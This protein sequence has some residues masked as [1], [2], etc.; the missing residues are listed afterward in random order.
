MGEDGKPGEGERVLNFLDAG[1]DQESVA[2]FAF[3]PDGR[4]AVT[5]GHGGRRAPNGR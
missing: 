2:F 4:L 1:I 3:L 5:C